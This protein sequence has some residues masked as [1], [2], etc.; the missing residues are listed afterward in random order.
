MSVFRVPP[1]LSSY[2]LSIRFSHPYG[3]WQSQ[4]PSKGWVGDNAKKY[5][6]QLKFLNRANA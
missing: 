6:Y 4:D 3:Q 2:L 5:L 1:S